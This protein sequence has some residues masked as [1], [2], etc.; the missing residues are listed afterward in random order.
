MINY[1]FNLIPPISQKKKIIEFISLTLIFLY[2]L[3]NNIKLLNLIMEDKNEL[4]EKTTS[5]I[6]K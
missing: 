3:L 4:G 5:L 1:S 2:I 6:A